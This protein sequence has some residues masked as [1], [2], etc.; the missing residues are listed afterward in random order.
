MLGISGAEVRGLVKL[1]GT[2]DVLISCLSKPYAPRE[3][4]ERLTH[5][6]KA[7]CVLGR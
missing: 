3:N 6:Y 4:K 7:L 5:M 2:S 1:C